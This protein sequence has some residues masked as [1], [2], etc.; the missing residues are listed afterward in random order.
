MSSA[1]QPREYS[2]G[3]RVVKFERIGGRQFFKETGPVHTGKKKVRNPIAPKSKPEKGKGKGKG[4][5][6][7]LIAGLAVLFALVLLEVIFQ[8]FVTPY[9]AIKEVRIHAEKGMTL[10]NDQILELSGL[11]EKSYYFNIK[12]DVLVERL[13]SYPLIRE[14]RVVKEFPNSLFISVSPREPLVV[15]LVNT[16]SFSVPLA[17]DANGVVFQIGSSV[18]ELDAPV[19]SGIQFKEL[20]LGMK[21]PEQLVSFLKD[22]KYLKTETPLLFSLISEIQFVRK[23]GSNF[24]VLFRTIHYPLPVRIGPHIDEYLLKYILVT[25]DVVMK[26]DFVSNIRELDFRNGEVVY[27]MKEE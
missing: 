15:S 13:E 6:K 25:L 16:E 5:K 12:P 21:L 17:L 26:Q 4:W 19:V 24:E 1:I 7:L 20:E 14:A 2:N 3:P 23:G 8:L 22:L 10:T 18:R 11:R 27:R 9:F